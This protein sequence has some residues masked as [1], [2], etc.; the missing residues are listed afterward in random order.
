MKKAFINL[1]LKKIAKKYY[2]ILGAAILAITIIH[3]ALQLS[4]I[5][6]E[7]L[8]VIETSVNNIKP[9]RQTVDNKEEGFDAEGY[10]AEKINDITAPKT[11][12]PVLRRQR[13]T[14][15]P[16]RILPKKKVNRESR[17]AR[18]RRA[19]KILTGV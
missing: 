6:T 12:Q 7:N 11:I 19:E 17:A 1:F 3:F 10:K 9:G 15:P 14:A 4:F 18:L 8:Q 5:Q 13:E 2:I 16:T